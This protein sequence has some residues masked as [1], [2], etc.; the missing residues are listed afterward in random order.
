MAAGWLH[1]QY[2]KCQIFCT[3]LLCPKKATHDKTFAISESYIIKK[4]G[5]KNVITLTIA[6]SNQQTALNE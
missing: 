1:K 5:T 4:N 6:G 2:D 3:H